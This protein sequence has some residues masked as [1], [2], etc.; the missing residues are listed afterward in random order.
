MPKKYVDY[1]LFCERISK[2]ISNSVVVNWL[3]RLVSEMPAADVKEVIH[4][5]WIYEDDN[6]KC[7]CSEC[8]CPGE[9]YGTPYCSTCGACM[10]NEE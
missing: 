4:G 6:G 7:H 5:E 2:S 10:E 1:D 9:Q 3:L 8:G